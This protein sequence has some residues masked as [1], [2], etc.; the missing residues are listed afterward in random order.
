M[1]SI[2]IPTGELPE[3]DLPELILRYKSGQGLARTSVKVCPACLAKLAARYYAK[4]KN[5]PHYKHVCGMK[6]CTE[7][8]KANEFANS[9]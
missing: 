8:F 3:H 2:T 4:R 5:Y 9:D 6:G 7:K 1:P